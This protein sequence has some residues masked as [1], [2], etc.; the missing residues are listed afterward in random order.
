MK[1]YEFEPYTLETLAGD[2]ERDVF[3]VKRFLLM[4]KII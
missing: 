1:T 2:R 4:N 3:G